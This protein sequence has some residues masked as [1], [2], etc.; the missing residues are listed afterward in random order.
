MLKGKKKNERRERRKKT[1][2]IVKKNKEKRKAKTGNKKIEIK[3]VNIYV[4]KVPERVQETH[5]KEE[6]EK[7]Y[8]WVPSLVLV[9]ED[10][11]G[12]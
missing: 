6:L 11:S 4:L 2:T 8:S 12:H 10:D 3:I 7:G 1:E 5:S 9:A